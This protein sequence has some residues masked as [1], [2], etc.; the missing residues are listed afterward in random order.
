MV[1]TTASYSCGPRAA[2]IYGVT[3]TIPTQESPSEA[4][5]RSALPAAITWLDQTVHLVEKTALA[6]PELLG[7]QLYLGAPVRSPHR[8]PRQR[9][10]LGYYFFSRT[11]Q[12]VWHESLLEASAL[13]QLDFEDDIVAI[14]A[15][16]MT[17][18]FADGTWHVPDY[19]ALHADGTQVMYDVKPSSLMKDKVLEQFF[20]TREVCAAVG[21]GYAICNELLPRANRN[22]TWLSNFKHP[23]YHPANTGATGVEDLVI[24]ATKPIT[25]GD[26]TRLIGARTMAE[27]RAGIYHLIWVGVLRVDLAQRINDKAFIEGGRH[28]RS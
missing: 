10:Y 1:R 27:A 18:R 12:H 5:D 22:L 17:I 28:A 4:G 26:A 11:G 14:A 6:A 13:R 21:W 23:G 9:N 24:A 7:E 20:K 3:D 8:Y 25:I 19:I 16:P 2:H 15:Q